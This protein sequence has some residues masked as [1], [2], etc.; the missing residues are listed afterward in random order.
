MGYDALGGIRS[1]A[2]NDDDER[3]HGHVAGL[4][5]GWDGV[6]MRICKRKGG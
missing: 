6:D 3:L 4:V 2:D 1:S 5:G